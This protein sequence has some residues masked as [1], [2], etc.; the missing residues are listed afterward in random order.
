MGNNTSVTTVGIAGG[1]TV[2]VFWLL[3]Y[4]APEFMESAPTGAEA[5]VTAIVSALVG[6]L[7]KHGG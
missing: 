7:V 2:V 1:I 6:Y 5:A 4:F 3:G